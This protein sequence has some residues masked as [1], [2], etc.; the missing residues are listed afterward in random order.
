MKRVNAYPVVL[1][2]LLAALP[3]ALWPVAADEPAAPSSKEITAAL[4]PFVDSHSLAG[5]VTLVA[6]KD[7]VLSLD[8]VGY[9]DV[10]AKTPLIVRAI[11]WIASMSKPITAAALMMLVDEGK[12]KLDDPVEKY[13]P[14]F[15]GQM[16]SVKDGNEQKLQKPA[17]PITVREILTHT[18]G[19]PFSTAKESP[20]KWQYSNAGINTAGR[21]IE[22]VTG[23]PYEDFLEKRLT[24]PLGMADTTFW[25]N[26]EQ[27]KRLAKPYRP[28]KDKK[29]LEEFTISQ[30]KYPLSDRKRQPMPAG[31][32]FATASDVGIFCQM[33]LNGGT[34]KGK[35]YLSESAVREMT[36]RQTREGIKENWGLGFTAGDNFGHG[37]ALA[38]NMNVDTKRGLIT[39]W[40]VQ[41]SG[42]G[43]Q[44]REA[45]QKAAEAQF[46]NSAK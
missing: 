21:I 10:G 31:G 16:L 38:T 7:K 17:H 9:A 5:A 41:H 20:T 27:L 13:L 24:G 46:G 29:S 33:M 36:R 37:G 22:V 14:E 30:L 4:Q 34:W 35:R 32:L 28:S 42:I 3:I 15:K 2:L 1:A 12:V 6:D 11:F 45:F 18:S 19:L 44:S 26:E 23:M 8:A 39:V 43:G 25:P 40:M